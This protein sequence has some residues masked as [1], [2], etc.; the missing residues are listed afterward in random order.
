[1]L[2]DNMLILADDD[3]EIFKKSLDK[4]DNFLDDGLL[5]RT[6]LYVVGFLLNVSSKKFNLYNSKIINKCL[7][8]TAS[9]SNTN[10]STIFISTN[11]TECHFNENL[12]NFDE[13]EKLFPCETLIVTGNQNLTFCQIPQQLNFSTGYKNVSTLKNMYVNFFISLQYDLSSDQFRRTFQRLFGHLGSAAIVNNEIQSFISVPNLFLSFVLG[14]ITCDTEKLSQIEVFLGASTTQHIDS[15]YLTHFN[16]KSKNHHENGFNDTIKLVFSQNSTNLH[17]KSN[18]STEEKIGNKLTQFDIKNW[19]NKFDVQVNNQYYFIRHR[20][21]SKVF[22]DYMH[23]N[24]FNQMYGN[25]RY[26]LDRASM[27]AD[28]S[29]I[30]QYLL[31]NIINS[32]ELQN[33]T[34]RRV[35]LLLQSTNNKSIYFGIVDITATND[36]LKC[37]FIKVPYTKEIY[38]NNVKNSTIFQNYTSCSLLSL[39]KT[40]DQRE[41]FDLKFFPGA[42]IEPGHVQQLFL[43]DIDID[44]FYQN[45]HPTAIKVSQMLTFNN[46]NPLCRSMLNFVQIFKGFLDVQSN[47]DPAQ[48]RKNNGT[49]FV[50]NFKMTRKVGITIIDVTNQTENYRHDQ[51]IMLMDDC[52]RFPIFT[53]RFNV[54]NDKL[55]Y[56]QVSDDVFEK[57]ILQNEVKINSSLLHE[58][59]HIVKQKDHL[60][61]FSTL[62]MMIT[63]AKNQIENINMVRNQSYD[64]FPDIFDR[65]QAKTLVDSATYETLARNRFYTRKESMNNKTHITLMYP[66]ELDSN[67]ISNEARMTRIGL[68]LMEEFN[69]RLYLIPMDS[70]QR[71]CQQETTTIINVIKHN[72]VDSLVLKEKEGKM[73]L[74]FIH[75]TGLNQYFDQR[76]LDTNKIKESMKKQKYGVNN[77]YMTEI[78]D[79]FRVPWNVSHLLKSTSNNN[80]FLS[81]PITGN[82]TFYI[83]R[84]G[85]KNMMQVESSSMV[86]IDTKGDYNETDFDI[87]MFPKPYKNHAHVTISNHVFV[88]NKASDGTFYYHVTSYAFKNFKAKMRLQNSNIVKHFIIF[89][90]NIEEMISIVWQENHTT[91]L[92]ICKLHF[93]NNSFIEIIQNFHKQ[94]NIIVMFKNETWMLLRYGRSILKG[95]TVQNALALSDKLKCAVM[96]QHAQSNNVEIALPRHTE[97]RNFFVPNLKYAVMNIFSNDPSN[98]K[99]TI[100]Y[101][102]SRPHSMLDFRAYYQRANDEKILL[103]KQGKIILKLKDKT[104]TQKIIISFKKLCWHLK[105]KNITID[106]IPKRTTR[107]NVEID[108]FSKHDEISREYHQLGTIILEDY[109]LYQ[110]V[111]IEFESLMMLGTDEDNFGIQPETKYVK[112]NTEIISLQPECNVRPISYRIDEK[113]NNLI[114]YRLESSLVI[115]VLKEDERR[116][117]FV[118][119]YGFFDFP[120]SFPRISFEFQNESIVFTRDI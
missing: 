84:K 26:I 22:I 45:P 74:S 16:K 41:K 32:N 99:D 3:F 35:I 38:H 18:N 104:P 111:F 5:F 67:E 86:Y 65:F 97:E 81:K 68:S 91:Q 57:T 46:N 88:Y 92:I 54:T 98:P 107:V 12:L 31:G 8:F 103:E 20:S 23:T 24:D 70:V 77:S 58:V 6:F 60:P 42:I 95:Y 89:P 73:D 33:T 19:Y 4:Y 1:M 101:I 80:H 85:V 40:M 21:L 29:Q 64:A 105:E 51:N 59:F 106:V 120:K 13:I 49:F 114:Y 79:S 14:F 72:A 9:N 43:S 36:R 27:I 83:G 76:I 115:R 90:F 69:N 102:D 11:L 50:T 117:I 2:I 25:V 119:C 15:I 112:P 75:R 61:A 87:I 17:N 48:I 116:D 62:S 113:V 28:K 44:Q 10:F 109:S 7:I 78:D 93:A 110:K 82:T 37:L 118:L 56:V 39:S 55:Q 94:S 66:D 108:I 100:I 52:N 30:Y 53:I 34:T 71:K 96:T 63:S 47:V